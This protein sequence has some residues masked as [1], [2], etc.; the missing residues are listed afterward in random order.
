MFCKN[1][2][3]EM[4]DDELFCSECGTPVK[5]ESVGEN[6][7]A[8]KGSILRNTYSNCPAHVGKEYVFDYYIALD[9]HGLR[10]SRRAVRF[11][12][13]HLLYCRGLMKTQIPYG[14]IREIKDETKTSSYVIACIVISVLLGI[15]CLVCGL[16][17]VTVVAI[18]L[19]IFS[20]IFRQ[21][22]QISILTMD[23]KVFKIK[24]VPKNQEIDEF[25]TYLK[26][27][28]GIR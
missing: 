11:N 26:D 2:G 10:L 1:C 24:V 21:Y 4:K 19:I 14:V 3:N 7:V 20:I 18:L 15:I 8:A 27:D 25:L 12:E 6:M 17:A 28:T 9:L 13:D 22:R 23:N 5:M 16:Y